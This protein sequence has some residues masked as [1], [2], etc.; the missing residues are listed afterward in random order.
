MLIQKAIDLI[1][2]NFLVLGWVQRYGG[3]VQTVELDTTK[4]AKRFP[5]SCNV[6]EQDCINNQFY[7]D[8]VPDSNKLSLLYWEITQ[9]FRD[10]GAV[11]RQGTDSIR[12]VRGSVRVVGWL[13]G[14]KLGYKECN[15]AARASRTI[16]P[17]V[18]QRI[19]S[20]SLV[21]TE[22]ENGYIQFRPLGEVVKDKEIFAKYDY[23]NPSRYLLFPYDYF[24]IDVLVEA[25]IYVGCDFVFDPLAEIDCVDNTKI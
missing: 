21:G 14:Q 20:D 10:V 22:F 11:I 16:W 19:E 9:G 18:N 25:S 5:V 15:L 3:V 2:G 24:A 4:G 12:R 23:E 6:S 8:L 17:I 1:S 13:N 7:Q